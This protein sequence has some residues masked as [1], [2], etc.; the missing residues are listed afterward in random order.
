MRTMVFKQK[1]AMKM[2]TLNLPQ[3]R[4]G[5]KDPAWKAPNFPSWASCLDLGCCRMLDE[6]SFFQSEKLGMCEWT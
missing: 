3:T 2:K 6:H 5:H 1:Q 4:R